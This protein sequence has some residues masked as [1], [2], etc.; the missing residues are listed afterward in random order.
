[1]EVKFVDAS[2]LV[3]EYSIARKVFI[4]LRQVLTGYFYMISF[5]YLV[6]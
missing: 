4:H 6:N 1:M 2:F 3:Y 5:N